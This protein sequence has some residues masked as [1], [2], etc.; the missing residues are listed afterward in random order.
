VDEALARFRERFASTEGPSAADADEAVRDLDLPGSGET[1]ERSRDAVRVLYET[2][3]S[4]GRAAPSELMAPVD[5]DELGYV[6]ESSFWSNT[7]REG[8]RSLPGVRQPA[9]GDGGWRFDPDAAT[10]DETGD[11]DAT[12][13]E[14]AAAGG[15]N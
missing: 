1:F 6:G 3:R 15:S 2:L 13:D 9:A 11:D 4:Q 14:E 12:A 5:P 10:A 8:M 7:G